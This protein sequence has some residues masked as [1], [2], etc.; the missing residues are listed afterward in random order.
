MYN[1]LNIL[2]LKH[3]EP[4]FDAF[5]KEDKVSY[6]HF[7][8]LTPVSSTSYRKE[9]FDLLDTDGG[10]AILSTKQIPQVIVMFCDKIIFE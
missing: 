8:D 9:G 4:L 1:N 10:Y 7:I 2:F 3:A 5:P 6:L